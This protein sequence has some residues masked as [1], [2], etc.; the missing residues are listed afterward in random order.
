MRQFRLPIRRETKAQKLPAPMAVLTALS[1]RFTLSLS[2]VVMNRV[3]LAITRSLPAGLRTYTLQSCRIPRETGGLSA[4]TETP[5]SAPAIAITDP[6]FDSG[7]QFVVRTRSKNFSRSKST[8][9]PVMLDRFIPA[10][11]DAGAGKAD[12]TGRFP[13][14]S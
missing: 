5:G 10:G 12:G 3:M 2:F 8:P 13:D 9:Q 4:P 11:G 14:H 7:H 1:A 6:G